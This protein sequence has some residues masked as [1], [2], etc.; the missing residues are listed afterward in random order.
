MKH[1]GDTSK[2][3]DVS[4]KICF[5]FIN[6]VS[7]TSLL[8]MKAQLLSA[9]KIITTNKQQA[10]NDNFHPG[11]WDQHHEHHA[12]C[13]PKHCKS[14]YLFHITTSILQDSDSGYLSKSLVSYCII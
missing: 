10:D 12:D 7:Q 5:T 1:L 9:E 6:F 3:L 4:P 11:F 8:K 13:S 14:T 2:K